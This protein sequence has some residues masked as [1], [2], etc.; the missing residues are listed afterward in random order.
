MSDLKV[1]DLYEKTSEKKSDKF[2]ENIESTMHVQTDIK[3]SI[4]DL[5]WIDMM[6][7]TLPYIDRI[8][9]NPN[10]F[11]INEEEVI[12]IELSKKV[13]VDS[14]KHLSKH[15]NLIQEVDK[16]TGDVTPR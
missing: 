11:I 2:I 13:T 8:F 12:K 10:R 1:M 15:T 16:K 4:R 7:E 5:E 14:I 3:D 6:I 9:R